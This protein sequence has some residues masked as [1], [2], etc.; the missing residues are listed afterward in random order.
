[1]AQT[2]YR[3]QEKHMPTKIG[4]IAAN[5][6]EACEN[7]ILLVPL[8]A[9]TFH[10]MCARDDFLGH[11]D[12]APVIENLDHGMEAPRSRVDEER[13]HPMDFERGLASI[14]DANSHVEPEDLPTT[15][16]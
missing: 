15:F 7:V 13:L 9:F 5:E 12:L 2:A 3:I 11:E 6:L 8:S 10:G 4:E 1:M 14:A 16:L